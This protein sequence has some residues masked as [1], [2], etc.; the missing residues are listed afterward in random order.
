MDV[1]QSKRNERGT[2]SGS[3]DVV[4]HLFQA[5]GTPLH[6]SFSGQMNGS[7]HA[8]ACLPAVEGPHKQG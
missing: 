1:G 3:G 6:C 5:S 2:Q 7:C 8:S 4:F